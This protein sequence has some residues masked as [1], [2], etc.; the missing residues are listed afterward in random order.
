MRIEGF[1]VVPALPESLQGLREMAYNLL[2]TWDD[3]VRVL[4]LRLDRELWDRSYQ[5][6]VLM[7]GSMSQAQLETLAADD[8]FMAF[9]RRTYARYRDYLQ[10]KP[11][12][13][14]HHAERPLMAYFSA[15]FGL[16]ECLPIYSGGLGVLSGHHLKSASDLGVPLVGVGL[17]YQQ[18]YF[19]QYLTSDGWQQES[20]PIND[21]FNLPVEPALNADGTPVRITLS[22]AGRPLLVQVWR[23]S[24]GRLS[25]FLLDTNLTENAPDLR[26]ITDQLYGGDQETRIQQEIVLGVGGLRALNAMGL[27]PAVCHMNEGHSAFL[28]LERIR[29]LM[30]EDG[31]D[32]PAARE[33]ARAGSVFT[34]HTPV[35]AG[36]DVFPPEL[37]G[38]YFGDYAKD[39][40]LSMKELLALGAGDPSAASF[41]MAGLALRA[42]AFVNGV[43]RL[44]GEVSRTMLGR[45]LPGIPVDE[46]PIGHVTNGAHIRSCVSRDMAALY[47][48]YLGPDW[49]RRPD[50]PD[51]WSDVDAIP[52]E[53]L[54]ATHER[55]RERL[56]AFAR[57]RLMKQV[58]QRGGTQR[59]IEHARGVLN[60]RAL[61]VGFARRFATYKRAGLILTDVERLK[62]LLL[63]ADRP[64][65]ILF[66]GKAHPR[67]HEAKE[68]L[69]SVVRLCQGDDVRRHVVFIEDYDLVVAREM[70]QG[71]DV[72]LNT[73]RRGLEASGTSGMKVVPNG[74]LNLSV[75]DGWWPEGYAP[76]TGWAIG[77]GESYDDHAYQDVVESNALYDV[78]EKDVVPLFYQRAADGLPRA[79]IARMKQ[80]MKRLAPQFSA[81]R[82]VWE[83]VDGYYLPAVRYHTAL[84]ADRG[85]RARALA[86]WKSR[87]FRH[88]PGVKI[89]Q[90]DAARPG[91]HRVGE[92]Y[93]LTAV[94][95]LGALGPDD[96][97]VE[98]YYGPLDARREVTEG[99]SLALR[100]DAALG[101]G[102][103]RF[104][105]DVPCDRSGML[106]FGLRVRPAHADANNVLCTGLMTWWG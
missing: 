26:D 84:V 99:R 81:N 66:A 55:R 47:D 6:P 1:Q 78:L 18:G 33:A 68:V 19:R 69:K 16:S 56:V 100:L 58:E 45:Y 40:G 14:A 86:E 21:F 27:R 49:W 95:A 32:F 57:R 62:R 91:V 88:W 63:S 104:R 7:L 87:V 35:P 89:E 25:L 96:V 76:E 9:F 72:W 75:L 31:L 80:A 61:T 24:V 39:L 94:V 11:W 53:E 102:K 22:M 42:S 30:K 44:H 93:P 101:G 51:T 60:T 83:Y 79:W 52:D 59:D 97:S 15:E 10:E 36:F 65:Q 71:V 12:W 2:W 3:D 43:S 67:D 82:M 29:L 20:Y 37:V 73:P 103:Y 74:G 50:A 64:V 85:T 77:K 13:D 5:N 8:G 92:T 70:V 28:S 17:L 105:G 54:W 98:A 38:K 34:T 4:F 106:G 46:I 23:V 41:N 48:R 90:V